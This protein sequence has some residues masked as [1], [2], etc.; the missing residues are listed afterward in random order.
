MLGVAT[1]ARAQAGPPAP[2]DTLRLTL[3]EARSIALQANPLL[4]AAR[5]D[6]TVA[7]G[8]VRQSSLLIAANPSVEV[9]GASGGNGYEA[10]VSQEIEIFGQ[11]GSRASAGRAGLARAKAGVSNATRLTL[12]DVDRTFYQ[13]Y[14]AT[15][16][17]R[18][19]EEVF[20][21]TQ[22]IADVA[23]RQ[24]AAGEIGRLEF[25]LATVELGRT[26][27]RALAAEREREGAAIELRRLLGVPSASPVAP[28][29]DSTDVVAPEDIPDMP[30]QAFGEAVGPVAAPE[31]PNRRLNLDSLIALALSR[32]PDLAEREAAMRQAEAQATTA[33][34]EALP[35]LLVRGV[36]EP[37]ADGT[38]RAFRPGIGLTLPLFNRNRGRVQAL[39][40]T[41]RRA[42]LERQ[43]LALG[44]RAQVSA[45][46][47]SFEAAAAEVQVLASTVLA[48]AR[49][50][51]RLV[52]IAYREGK[53]GLP[54]LLLIRN[55]AIDAELDYWAA[56]LAERQALA[57]LAEATSANHPAIEESQR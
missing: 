27:T 50:N 36:T 53:V 29:L 5:L 38:G 1:P 55:Q 37:S 6:T 46:A 19:A 22:R 14:S 54:E 28:V 4:G 9:L 47:A 17:R 49:Q 18:L 42:E 43:S 35:N 3:V 48:P 33:R 8:E 12:G 16:R 40:A 34:R 11:Q 51:R 56:W 31:P 21:L 57:S 23:R 26:R 45:A 41:A 20:A 44:I 2:G 39:R 32:R 13:L 10:G 52:E 15:R 7:R 24:L 30:G 25:N